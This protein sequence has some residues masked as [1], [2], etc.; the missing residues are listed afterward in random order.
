MERLLT[1]GV[2]VHRTRRQLGFGFGG[3]AGGVGPG[4][5][6]GQRLQHAQ[7]AVGG[8]Q[9]QVLLRDVPHLSAAVPGLKGQ[10]VPIRKANEGGLRSS[11]HVSPVREPTKVKN[12]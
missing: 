2:P 7:Q 11:L 8:G 3:V 1:A 9:L 6:R 10:E 12:V 5:Q 4:V